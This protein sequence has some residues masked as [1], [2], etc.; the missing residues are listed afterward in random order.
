[1]DIP[2][3]TAEAETAA[4]GRASV[5]T[6]L[7]E[8]KNALH[9]ICKNGM[10]IYEQKK[11]CRYLQVEVRVGRGG[12]PGTAVGMP[13]QSS[14][15]DHGGSGYPPATCGGSKKIP[16]LDPHATGWTSVKQSSVMLQCTLV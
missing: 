11:P 10:R 2:W 15:E 16:E 6:Y 14:G 12:A 13:L 3:D 9:S 4:A 7:G 1:M 8:G 5:I